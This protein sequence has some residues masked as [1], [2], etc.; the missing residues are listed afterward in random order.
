[1]LRDSIHSVNPRGAH[2]ARL[3]LPLVIHQV[4]NHQ[5]PVRPGKQPAESNSSG[6][7]VSIV[8]IGRTFLERVVLHGGSR[9]EMT[10]QF[11]DA[12]P[13][14]HQVNFHKTELLALRKVLCRFTRQVG[15]PKCTF[16]H[17]MYHRVPSFLIWC[18]LRAR[19]VKVSE[20]CCRW[21][22]D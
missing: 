11:G 10:S 2:R 13:L 5:R 8:E 9:R 12:L 15:L 6:R 17:L 3:G 19:R 20:L 7:R 16:D 1:M 14:L 22:W 18:P 4:I 21:L